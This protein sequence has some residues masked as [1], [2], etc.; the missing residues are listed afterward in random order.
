MIK[1]QEDENGQQYFLVHKP[2]FRTK[3]FE[4]LIKIIDDSYLANCSQKSK[5]QM[6]RREVGAPIVRFPPSLKFGSDI[7]IKR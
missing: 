4:K 6:I 7:F 5:D 1:N 3:T 2:T